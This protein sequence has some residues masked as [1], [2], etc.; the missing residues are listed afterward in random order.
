LSFLKQ[1]I[2]SFFLIFFKRIFLL[3]EGPEGP[4]SGL[5][6]ASDWLP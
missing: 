2:D 6:S 5:P 1:R 4:V 3:P